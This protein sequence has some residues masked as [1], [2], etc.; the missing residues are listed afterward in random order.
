VKICF[1]GNVNGALKGYTVGGAELQIALLAKALALKGHEVV[2][3]NF[4][5]DE[6]YI[7]SE[8][9]HV[10]HVP[11]WNKGFRAVR[12]IFY[13]LPSLWQLFLEQRADYYYV[14]TRSFFHLIP[15]LAAQKLNAR[16][17][18]A[19]AHDLDV[20]SLSERIKHEYKANSTLS[21]FLT[22][23]LWNDLVF[24][25]LLKR[26]DFVFMQHSG[27]IKSNISIKGKVVLLPN[28]LDK[29]NVPIQKISSSN[30]FIHVGTLTVLKGIE[31]LYNLVQLI[32]EETVIVIVGEA[33]D[34]SSVNLIEK[35]KQ[36]K[37]IVLWGRADHATTIELISNS[38]A[39]INTSNFEGFPNIFLEAWATGVPVISLNVNPGNV[40]NEFKTGIFCNGD[41]EKMKNC[42]ENFHQQKFDQNDLVSYVDTFHGFESAAE[43]F[44]DA[45]IDNKF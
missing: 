22:L 10:L 2:I 15:F 43:R 20:M 35:I 4:M 41:I 14:R 32:D 29:K 38:K 28:I 37:N 3:I 6:S 30:Y 42:L 9:I 33:K 23:S 17:I 45:I 19:I 44:M 18:L 40:L 34:K 31:N 21:N 5:S 25:Y 13:R 39:L 24:N 27:Q 26:S 12:F 36:K 7:T 16:F 8:G 1:W 11:N